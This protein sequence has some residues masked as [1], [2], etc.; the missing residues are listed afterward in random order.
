MSEVV[1]RKTM[2]KAL[3][4][5]IT[6]QDGSYLAEYLLTKN[7][8][9]SG[10]VRRVSTD[11]TQNIKHLTYSGQ[12]SLYN[13][14]MTSSSNVFSVISDI[15]P[16]EVYNLAAQSDVRISFD[17]PDYTMAVN[18]V[19]VTNILEALRKLHQ[20]S[21]IPR[22]YQASTSELFGKV[23]ETP[24]T[25]KTPF[26]PR[27]PYGVSKLAAHWMT[28]NYRES[29]NM[30]CSTG[31]LFNHESPRRGLNFVTRK[32]VHGMKQIKN[33][34]Q[35]HIELG[36]L[37]SYRDWGHAKDYVRAMHLI[38]Q[39]PN[40]SDYVIATGE[41]HSIRELVEE[42]GKNFD[43]NI[44]WKGEG[45]DELGID[46]NTGRIVVKINPLFY[47]PAEVDLLLGNPFKAMVDL[48]WE[49]EYDFKSLIKDMCDNE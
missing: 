4:T 23:Q 49:R 39:A 21:Y 10:L 29:Y 47:R 1:H 7:Y 38:L 16:D 26:Y 32:V 18:A 33:G 15:K 34:L 27:S 13:C 20:D 24:Q 43:M 12:I 14:D 22:F 37:D 48:G 9:V 45:I 40:P 11:N 35:S 6:G 30:F 28:I 5:G 42:V 17:M 46:V 36:N 3:I 25:E 2:K 41:K 8:E 31:I 44:E 19:G